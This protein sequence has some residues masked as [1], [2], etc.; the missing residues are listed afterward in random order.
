MTPT[1][2][3]CSLKAVVLYS[4]LCIL[5]VRRVTLSEFDWTQIP[6]RAGSGRMWFN[7][8]NQ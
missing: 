2:N 6:I 8:I 3:P 7:Y 1:Y 4:D 5:I